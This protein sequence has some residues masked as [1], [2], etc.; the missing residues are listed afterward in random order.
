MM[1]LVCLQSNTTLSLL[2][3][4]TPEDFLGALIFLLLPLC[5]GIRYLKSI[6]DFDMAS[7]VP[8][9]TNAKVTTFITGRGHRVLYKL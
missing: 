3:F 1:I 4:A 8:K 9:I 5:I 2:L 6:A 7:L